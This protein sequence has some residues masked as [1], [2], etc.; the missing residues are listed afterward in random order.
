MD[1]SRINKAMLVP[2]ISAVL[3]IVKASFKLDFNE[4]EWVDRIVEAVLAGIALIGVFMIPK[5]KSS[6]DDDIDNI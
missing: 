3:L 1:L 6:E 4:A 5:K 2:I